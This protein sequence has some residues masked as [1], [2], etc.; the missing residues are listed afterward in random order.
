MSPGGADHL[1]EVVEDEQPA[2]VAEE[3]DQGL[4]RRPRPGQLD[5]DRPGD[6]R[7]HQLRSGDRG[8][9][10][11]RGPRPEAVGQ[12]LAHR[13]G[14]PGLADPTQ[15]GEGHQAHVGPTD[16]T[17]HLVDGLRPPDQRRRV[18]RQRARLARDRLLRWRRWCRC[19]RPR[20]RELL[21]QQR[22]QVVAHQPA[23]LPAGAEVPV[24]DPALRLDAAQ[25]LDQARLPVRRRPL[26][27]QQPGKRLRQLELVLQTRDVH[28]RADPPVPL[29]V[30]ADEHVTLRQVRPVELLRRVRP[31]PELEHH[32]RQPQRRD[33]P[34][35]R[36][37]LLRHLAER[38]A[39]EHPQTLVR[40]PDDLLPRQPRVPRPPPQ[41]IHPASLGPGRLPGQQAAGRLRGQRGKAATWSGPV[42][43]AP[44]PAK[45]ASARAHSR[46]AAAGRPDRCSPRLSR[47]WGFRAAP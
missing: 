38:G 36:L 43:G 29:P 37:P 16:Q 41:R 6:A 24:G 42:A 30:Q 3:L 10:H 35:H 28:A 46:R 8:Q 5:P 44:Q 39:H 2:V 33:R 11:E 12:P 9:R 13:D 23:Q 20:R 40:R 31:G 15:P 45:T 4:Q 32:R 22:G 14:Q 34:R 19:R 47:W 21:A 7:Q 27:V 25:H 17:G 18:D 1:L 26:D